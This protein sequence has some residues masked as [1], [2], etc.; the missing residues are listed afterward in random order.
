MSVFSKL[1]QFKDLRDQGKRLQGAL[2]GESATETAAFGKVSVTVDGSLN[3][4]EIKIDD[5]LM[6]PDKKDKVQGA[7][8][9]AHNNAMKKMQRVISAKMQQMGGFDL[10]GMKQ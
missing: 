4:S 6:A 2:S 10:P 1:K 5:E 3:I 7:I 8:K 9:D